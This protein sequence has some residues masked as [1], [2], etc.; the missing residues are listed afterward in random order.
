MFQS[1]F[2]H[3]KRLGVKTAVGTELPMG[4]EKKGAEVEADWVRGIPPALQAHLKEKGLDP[5]D[6]EVV[7]EI[8]KGIFTRIMK[9]HDL[10]YYWLWTWEVWQAYD[11]THAQIDAVKRGHRP[12][13]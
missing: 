2:A 13:A 3:A 4:V 9:T 8:Y 6:P 5:K 11:M 1:A 7:K 12:G 10:D